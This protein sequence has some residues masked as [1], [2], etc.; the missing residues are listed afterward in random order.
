M[1]LKEKDFY[2]P[3]RAVLLPKRYAAFGFS[4]T[5]FA[6]MPSGKVLNRVEN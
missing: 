6:A 5:T 3:V 2:E 1:S 4:K